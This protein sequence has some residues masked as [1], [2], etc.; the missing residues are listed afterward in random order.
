MERAG[1]Y[2]VPFALLLI[3]TSRRSVRGLVG[4]VGLV[5]RRDGPSP[6]EEQLAR[7]GETLKWTTALLLFGH[8]ALGAVTGT[9]LLAHN[10]AAVGLP[11]STAMAIGWFEMALAGAVVWRPALGLLLFVAAWKIVTESL[12]IAA[13]A[14]I[15]ES[16]E[17][18]GSF[19]APLALAI[20]MSR[21][22][23]S[24]P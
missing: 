13:G 12:F 14:P 16:V 19:A 3:T 2:G 17:R 9:P 4:L 21:R 8:G 5:A 1:N 23:L 10:Y 24:Q 18:A 20:L 6:N 7:A 22:R 11:E 15:W